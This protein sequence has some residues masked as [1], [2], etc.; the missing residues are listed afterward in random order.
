MPKPRGKVKTFQSDW[1][2][3]YG[4]EDSTRN[5]SRSEVVR[6]NVT[7]MIKHC[8]DTPRYEFS[9]MQLYLRH[10]EMICVTKQKS[11]IAGKI[12]V[13]DQ[14]GLLAFIREVLEFQGIVE[15]AY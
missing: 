1:T 14:R 2:L 11:L 3:I 4:L 13:L 7:I 10:A 8:C 5:P 12:E 6:G 9:Y 15:E